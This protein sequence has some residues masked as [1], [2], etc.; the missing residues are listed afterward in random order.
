MPKPGP[1]QT[2][3]PSG[4]ATP[5]APATTVCAE[6]S[7]APA[8]TIS[9]ENADADE[10][11][12]VEH[13]ETANTP[14][15][16]AHEPRNDDSN[17]VA[18]DNNTTAR[19]PLSEPVPEDPAEAPSSST[20]S[21]VRPRVEPLLPLSLGQ[22]PTFTSAD[23]PP[24]YSPTHTILPHY[25]SLEPIPVRTYI[26]KD[27]AALPFLYDFWLCSTT[28]QPS[29]SRPQSQAL[30][31]QERGLSPQ[32]H[33]NELK[34]CLIRPQHTD[35]TAIPVTSSSAPNT[36]FI[37]ALALVAANYPARWIWWGTEALQMVVFGRQLKNIIM[38]WRWRHGRAR[39]GGPIVHRL[40]GCSFRVTPERKYC[41][42]QGTGKKRPA[43][44]AGHDRTTPQRSRRPGG[45][46]SIVLQPGPAEPFNRVAGNS[47]FGSF[48][49]RSTA[50]ATTGTWASGTSDINPPADDIQ[51]DQVL[52]TIPPT[53]GTDEEGVSVDLATV[54]QEN[55]TLRERETAADIDND[56]EDEDEELG[57]YHCRE[58]SSSGITGRVVAV[59]KP[60]R[61]ANRARDRPAMSRKLEIY[62]ELGERCETAMM[63]MCMRLDDLFM[64]IPDDRKGPFVS[65]RSSPG[66]GGGAD[67]P[68]GEGGAETNYA[69][70]LGE[71]EG[72]ANGSPAEGEGGVN[73][74]QRSDV[75]VMKRILGGR[76]AWRLWLKW[77]I[78]V[79]LIAVVVVLILKPKLTHSS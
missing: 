20:P 45:R 27:S 54:P 19:P 63:L 33:R 9:Q 71:G 14:I 75:L 53:L 66:Q 69:Q 25:F 37:P 10:D 48:F 3:D 72:G 13:Q 5:P 51:L 58:E 68:T 15:A 40:V 8:T 49:G 23:E 24:P 44:G 30:Q 4:V 11:L 59:Y 41:W 36:Y 46:E 26:I 77:I 61:P 76:N 79:I 29:S 32:H 38:E 65:T 57:C 21:H 62:T 35:R 34:Y 7:L 18:T 31:L 28:Q 17:A 43:N 1:S 12:N 78:G 42:K 16:T 74:G 2:V 64:S 70:G 73:N 6:E 56:Q 60:S 47:W 52:V 39:I 55:A 50:T 67:A 22:L